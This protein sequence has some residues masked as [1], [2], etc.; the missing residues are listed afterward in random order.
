MAG[1]IS[2]SPA[3][4]EDLGD[5]VAYYRELNP[6]TARRYFEEIVSS[7][8]RL[9]EYPESGRVVPEFEAY[10]ELRYREVVV[11]QFRAIYRADSG[12]V[13]VVRIVDGRRLISGDILPQQ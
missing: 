8:R 11:E 7:L 6:E 4:K 12:G 3:A 10:G 1:E 5:I 9:T 2:F 13:V